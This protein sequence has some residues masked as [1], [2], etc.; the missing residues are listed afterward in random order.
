MSL[1][2]IKDQ[3]HSGIQLSSQDPARPVDLAKVQE[4]EQLIGVKIPA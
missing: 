3:L 1:K 4:I 2:K